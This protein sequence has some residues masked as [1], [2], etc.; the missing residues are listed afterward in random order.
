MNEKRDFLLTSKAEAAFRQASQEVMRVAKQTGT[1][2]IVWKDGRVCEIP[3]I[4][5][6]SRL[7]EESAHRVRQHR[8]TE[9]SHVNSV[10]LAATMMHASVPADFDKQHDFVTVCVSSS[11]C[12]AILIGRTRVPAHQA[13]LLVTARDARP[14]D[15]VV[16]RASMKLARGQGRTD[17]MAEMMTTDVRAIMDRTPFDVSAVADLREVLNRDPSRYRTLR[18]AVANDPRA[19]EERTPSPRRISRLGVGDV[20]LGRYAS[21]LEH[22]KRAGEIGMAFFFQGLAVR[23]HAEVRRGRQGLRA[24]GQAGLRRQELRA[25]PR[26]GPA[27]H[28]ARG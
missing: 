17:S 25:A 14:G 2:V 20:L 18:D 22:L 11:R 21:G 24:R 6:T 12:Y 10:L 5:T 1:P 23:E 28:R 27:P 8:P 7:S 26:R 15:E 4:W 3:A 19:R 16:L 13:N 9:A